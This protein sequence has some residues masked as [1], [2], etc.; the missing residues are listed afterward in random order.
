MVTQISTE[1][2]RVKRTRGLLQTAF[3]ALLVEKGF[4]GLTVQDIA[5][6]ATVNRVTFYAHFA[7]KYALLD[8]VIR[9]EFARRVAQKLPAGAPLTEANLRT[10]AAA[11]IELLGQMSG[12]CPG[13][14][15]QVEPL[16]A[17]TLQGALYDF[18]LHWLEESGPAGGP[19][20]APR[21]TTAAV[22][23]W[24]IF[25]TGIQRS[26]VHPDEPA[27]ALADQV[28]AVLTGGLPLVP[29]GAR[30]APRAWSPRGA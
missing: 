19:D 15:K 8:S 22:L 23:S 26:R 6:R 12:H 29:P 18:L 16:F 30:P 20:R 21:E 17:T 10:L 5:D 13:T 4:H 9:E 24:A 14:D 2:P 25:G 1:D 7:D 28:I 11:V 3:A 27:D